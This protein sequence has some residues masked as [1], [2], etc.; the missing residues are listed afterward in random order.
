MS[1]APIVVTALLGDAD[2][3]QLNAL[4][5]AHFP[6]ERNR[7]DAHL[8]MF[9]HLPPSL[10]PEL[11]DRLASETRGLRAPAAR[12]AGIMN[13]GQG[14]AFRVESDG[15][16]DIRA[17]LAEAFSGM[18]TP[19]DQAGWRAH[20]TIQNKVTSA[21]ARA[22]QGEI[23]KSFAPRPLTIAG[24]ASWRYLGGT[25]EPIARHRFAG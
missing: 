17:R 8:T 1:A 22:L 15:L 13:L 10:E 11:R 5:R 24:L 6:P 7:L 12:L 25:W 9:H 19:Q 18:L 20:V 21:A 16:A 14:T 2:F 23:A 3:A 4:R